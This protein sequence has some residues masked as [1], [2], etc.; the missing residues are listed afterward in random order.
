MKEEA[1]IMTGEMHLRSMLMLAAVKAAIIVA[2]KSLRTKNR[3]KRCL[4]ISLRN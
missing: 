4:P 1:N 2:E 3:V